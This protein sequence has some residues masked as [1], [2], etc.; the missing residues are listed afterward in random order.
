MDRFPSMSLPANSA[1]SRWK[2]SI[3]CAPQPA[4]TFGTKPPPEMGQ[5]DDVVNNL[6]RAARQYGASTTS[7]GTVPERDASL[8]KLNANESVYGPSPKAVVAMRTALD[9]CHL[10]P[11]DGCS[12]LRE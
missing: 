5:F 10:Y 12:A 7:S 1:P 11:D 8:I 4:K 2:K 3:A 6:A 9:S